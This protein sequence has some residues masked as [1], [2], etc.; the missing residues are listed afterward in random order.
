MREENVFP[1]RVSEMGVDVGVAIGPENE[2]TNIT[3]AP[4][5]QSFR[6][7]LLL[8]CNKESSDKQA[9][10][11]AKKQIIPGK[12]DWCQAVPIRH[13]QATVLCEAR[14]SS[15]EQIRTHKVLLR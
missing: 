2:H 15:Q 1:G 9:G 6:L 8:R 14:D 3:G 10:Q 4:L 11:E 12:Q 7:W 5:R 13:E